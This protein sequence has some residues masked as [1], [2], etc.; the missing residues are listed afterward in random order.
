MKKTTKV[1]AS[2]ITLAVL[3]SSFAA[4]ILFVYDNAL[5]DQGEDA[6]IASLSNHRLVLVDDGAVTTADADGMDAVIISS[7]A[8]SSNVGSTFRNVSIPVIVNEGWLFD[9]M[10]M[11]WGTLNQ[12]YGVSNKIDMDMLNSSHPLA[13]GLTGEIDIFTGANKLFWAKPDASAD[14]VAKRTDKRNW[15][16]IFVYEEGDQMKGM[17]APAIRIGFGIAIEAADYWTT[18]SWSLFDAAV[19]YAVGSAETVAESKVFYESNKGLYVYDNGIQQIPTGNHTGDY[20]PTVSGSSIAWSEHSDGNSDVFIYNGTQ[21]TNISDDGN[22]TEDINPYVS[23]TNVAWMKKTNGIYKVM[24]WD[25]T[26][27]VAVSGNA[28][29]GLREYINDINGD[30][31]LLTVTM[32]C[33]FSDGTSWE[34]GH[35]YLY[36]NSTQTLTLISDDEYV[37]ENGPRISGSNVCWSQGSGNSEEIF[38]WSAGVISQVTNNNLMD[39]ISDASDAGFIWSTSDQSS[40]DQPVAFSVYENTSDQIVT[41]AS[42][43]AT[44]EGL[45]HSPVITGTKAYYSSWTN[46]TNGFTMHVTEYDIENDSYMSIWNSTLVDYFERIRSI[47][48]LKAADG[49]SVTWMAYVDLDDGEFSSIAQYTSR[50]GNVTS[51]YRPYEVNNATFFF[52]D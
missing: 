15:Y 46:D 8:R 14:M 6:V 27:T 35:L 26:N 45:Y 20:Y 31:V 1:L 48:P 30:S 39:K 4:D 22:T 19:A 51:Y 44:N 2:I 17:T 5:P 38:M 13:A 40:W 47:S 25:G 11:T 7:S 52:D 29:P 24:F 12:H 33:D 28:F 50:D 36:V 42:V 43:N 41:F 16:T 37:T 23:G 3:A 10:K 49:N 9:D 21:T 18:E 32:D 34:T